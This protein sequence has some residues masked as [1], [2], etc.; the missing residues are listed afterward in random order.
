MSKV[1]KKT[2]LLAFNLSLLYKILI[3]AEK[4]EARTIQIF[5]KPST[6]S[7][8]VLLY[9]QWMTFESI[10]WKAKTK[11]PCFGNFNNKTIINTRYVFSELYKQLIYIY[12]FACQVK[13]NLW[14]NLK[15]DLTV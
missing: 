4:S 13:F 3:T 5:K 2:Y 9:I 10:H 11:K 12:S 7:I 14:L 1:K 6:A 15:S 8:N